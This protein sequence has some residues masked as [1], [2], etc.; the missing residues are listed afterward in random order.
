MERV[1]ANRKTDRR[2]EKERDAGVENGVVTLSISDMGTAGHKTAHK[3]MTFKL[4]AP[5]LDLS[6][7][8]PWKKKHINSTDTHLHMC[9]H[10]SLSMG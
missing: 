3:V 2:Q 7:S 10:K 9:K 4:E 1:C 8:D 5:H 6:L